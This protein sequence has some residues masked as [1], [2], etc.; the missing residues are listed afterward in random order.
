[1]QRVT[2]NYQVSY[3]SS[4]ILASEIPLP[5]GQN[6][7]LIPWSVNPSFARMGGGGGNTYCKQSIVAGSFIK[8]VKMM[9]RNQREVKHGDLKARA[10]AGL[11]AT[12]K[13]FYIKGKK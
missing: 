10:V 2:Q 13:T 6:F 5:W 3:K 11:A 9:V 1:M 4:F 8:R 7:S 12:I